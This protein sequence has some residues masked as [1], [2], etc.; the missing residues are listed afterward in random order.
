MLNT[1][2]IEWFS[3]ILSETIPSFLTG[4]LEPLFI[5]VYRWRNSQNTP[6]ERKVYDVLNVR[7]TSRFQALSML[8]H[9]CL[10]V[11]YGMGYKK[12][13]VKLTADT[14]REIS[15]IEAKELISLHKQSFSTYWEWLSK[16][17]N[18]YQSLIPI[19]TRDGWYL[20][21]DNPSMP[22]VKNMPVQGNGAAIMRCA[23]RRAHDAGLRVLCPLHD[24]IYIEHDE[25]DEDAPR[26][27][28][29]CMDAAVE[30]ILGKS[31]YIRGDSKTLNS[32]DVWIEKKG[33]A[34]YD[35]LREYIMDDFLIFDGP[36][37]D[38]LAT[39]G[40]R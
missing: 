31:I 28:Q 10:G 24:A 19:C 12:L 11:Q 2:A 26:L 29:E 33:K 5:M 18:I 6:Q 30:D 35:S 38:D 15:Q 8:A 17:E 4:L 9:N 22:S 27:L 34:M 14:K 20:F 16:I 36:N 25:G 13:A 39:K 3:L 32:S 21:L 1:R 37:Y 40:R 23:I 7:K